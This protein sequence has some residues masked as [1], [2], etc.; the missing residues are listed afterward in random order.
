MEENQ[1]S[2]YSH[3]SGFLHHISNT[4]GDAICV[5]N[6]DIEIVYHNQEFAIMFGESDKELRGKR[7]GASI[8]CSG[9]EKIVPDGICNNCKLRLSMH[10]A[11]MSGANQEKQMMVLEMETGSKEELRLIQFKSNFMEYQGEKFAVV[12]LNDLTRMGNETLN[13]INKFYSIQK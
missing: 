10:A 4:L 3:D 13:F 5:V 11:M 9:H 2:K 7:F 8:G 6:T 12:V 1:F